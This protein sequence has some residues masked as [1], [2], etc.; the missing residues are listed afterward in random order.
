M[1]N[2]RKDPMGRRFGLEQEFFLVEEFRDAF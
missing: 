2:A 1:E